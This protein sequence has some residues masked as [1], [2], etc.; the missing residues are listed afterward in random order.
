MRK[1]G[2]ANLVIIVL[3]ILIV[4]TASLAL[5]LIIK[6]FNI[7]E[8]GEKFSCLQDVDVTILSACYT[9]N[10]LQVEVKNNKAPAIGDFLLF[11]FN[12]Q[13][14]T[15]EK[16]PTPPRTVIGAYEQK[17]VYVAYNKPITE[18]YII[19]RLQQGGQLCYDN[20][21]SYND[22]EPC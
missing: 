21:P 8:E 22:L 6:N 9:N 19:P 14:G 17:T 1:R 20:S 7:Y 4:V 13:D 10:V 2:N 16:I 3:L 12:Y 18:F 11:L 15:S 5:L